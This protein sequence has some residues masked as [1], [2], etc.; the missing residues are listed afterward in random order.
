MTDTSNIS[1]EERRERE[2]FL[3]GGHDRILTPEQQ[4]EQLSTY[5]AAHYEAPA[6][7]P[8][9]SDNPSD[10]EAIDTFDARLPDRITHACMLM[11]GSALGHTMPGV[12]FIDGVTT[13]DVPE[14]GGQ[15]IRPANPS[16]AWAISLH[17]GGWWKGSGVALD[18]AWRPEVAAVANLSGVTFLDL[19]Y[20]LVPEHTLE[21]VIATVTT[22]AQWVRDNQQPT[23]LFAWGYSSG[24]ALTTL[25]HSL[26]DAQALTFP[27]L[28]LTGLPPEVVGEVSF[29]DAAQFPPTLM[30][31]A[32]ND[33]IAG[34]YP[35]AEE[36]EQVRVQEYVSEHRVS[37]PEVARQRVR[38]V[39]EF[40][41]HQAAQ[42]SA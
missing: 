38:D 42:H 30:Q 21:Q 24:G 31:V 27:H 36:P 40:F 19:D 29:P 34:H 41:A 22:A 13:E 16:G 26:W 12:A 33:A 20:P 7:N 2:E 6:K 8:P 35:W 11:L 4:L 10:K 37:T 18:N 17:P 23:A 9:W 25:T 28:D 3:I 1:P 15:I 5:I 14:L 39:A 32:S